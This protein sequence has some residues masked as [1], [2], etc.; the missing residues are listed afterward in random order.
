MH[1]ARLCAQTLVDRHERVFGVQYK[2]M[3]A[4]SARHEFLIAIKCFLQHPQISELN[5]D[6]QSLYQM[7][8]KTL[9][10]TELKDSL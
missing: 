2:M 5:V 7:V 10:S 3:L 4:E 6:W 8:Y 1:L 9:F